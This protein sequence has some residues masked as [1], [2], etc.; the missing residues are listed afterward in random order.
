MI[1]PKPNIIWNQ[2]GKISL[3]KINIPTYTINGMNVK[4]ISLAEDAS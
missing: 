4:V 3:V 2:M 1:R